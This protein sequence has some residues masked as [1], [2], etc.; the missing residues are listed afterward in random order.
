MEILSYKEE[1]KLQTEEKK[2]YYAKLREY[3]L[4]RKLTN[5][6]PLATKIGPI[7]KKPTGTIC[8]KVC[9]LLAG[10]SVEVITDGFNERGSHF[11]VHPDSGVVF[12]GSILPE[13][14]QLLTI[15]EEAASELPGVKVIGWDFAHTD[16]GWVM[17]EGNAMSQIEVLQIPMQKGMR[18]DFERYFREMEPLIKYS[19]E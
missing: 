6:T 16:K 17:V 1:L 13:W 19:F 15:A 9:K 10:G 11:P 12:K 3:C 2:Q 14:K 5:T 7:L 8:R 4:H 18:K